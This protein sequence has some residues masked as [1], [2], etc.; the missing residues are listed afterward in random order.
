MH[1]K[2][3]CVKQQNGAYN[4]QIPITSQKVDRIDTSEESQELRMMIDE[5]KTMCLDI[6]IKLSEHC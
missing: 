5:K 6:A 3:E 2:T 4:R 1:H